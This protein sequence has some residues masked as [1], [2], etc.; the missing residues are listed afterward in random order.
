MKNAVVDLWIL[1]ADNDLKTGKDELATIDPVTD[2]VCFH[3][4]QCAEKYFKAFLVYRG[5]EI[6]RTHNLAL[7]LQECIEID[8]EFDKLKQIGADEL[9]S[10]AIEMRYPDDF[11]MP[12]LAEAQRARAIAEEVRQF[13]LMKIMK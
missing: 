11:Y 2:T 6:S 8:G 7:L 1:R 10:F 5:R 4:Q 9:T 13:V 3:M 12:S